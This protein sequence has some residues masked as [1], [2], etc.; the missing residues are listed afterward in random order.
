M[1]QNMQ[2]GSHGHRA[3]ATTADSGAELFLLHPWP[4]ARGTARTIPVSLGV[5]SV[6]RAVDG[7]WATLDLEENSKDVSF[8]CCPPRPKQEWSIVASGG[9]GSHRV[10]VRMSFPKVVLRKRQK[11][12]C[13]VTP[14][15]VTERH[16]DPDSKRD[17]SALS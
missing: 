7:G 2:G 15:L 4:S 10:P 1:V 11:L 8:L 17:A 13:N 12:V 3:R 16:Q 14:A 5:N 9:G 6:P